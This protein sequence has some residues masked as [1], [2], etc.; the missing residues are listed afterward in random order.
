[1]TTET[2]VKPK[3]SDGSIG[4]WPP[5]AHIVRKGADPKEGDKALCGAKL[6]GIPLDSAT[7]VCAKCIEIVK[8]EQ[9]Q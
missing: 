2:E 6:M 3:L 4:E 7:K 5:L 8:M 9:G 1:M